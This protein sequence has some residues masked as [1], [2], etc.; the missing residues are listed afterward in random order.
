MYDTRW[1]RPGPAMA[2]VAAVV[3]LVAGVI[4]GFSSPGSQPAAQ[5]GTATATSTRPPATTLPSDF[6]TVVLGSFNDLANADGTMRRLRE[7]GV[8]DAGV[9]RQSDYSSLNTAYAVYSGRFRTQAEAEAHKVELAQLG[10]TK[11]YLKHVTR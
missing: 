11:S 7:E 4:L 5:A 3:G 2:A 10:I 1:P 8:D 9:L 6:H